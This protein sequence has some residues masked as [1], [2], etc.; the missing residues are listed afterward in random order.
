MGGL[1]TGNKMAPLNE[2]KDDLYEAPEC[3]VTIPFPPARRSRTKTVLRRDVA[4]TTA[5]IRPFIHAGEAA[6]RVLAG[7]EAKRER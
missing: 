4:E 5:D 7:I 3:A 1:V 6:A 2:R